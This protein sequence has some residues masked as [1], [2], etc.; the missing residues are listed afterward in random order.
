M[1]FD[2]WGT[3]DEAKPLSP[4]ITK[5]LS[6]VMGV[7]TD[8]DNTVEADRIVLSESRLGEAAKAALGKIVGE[9]KLT[10]DRDQR[11]ARA[12]GKSSLDLLE[13]R[14]GEEISAPDAVL[15][16]G[17]EEEILAILEYCSDNRIAVVP[18]GGGTSVVGGINPARGEF[19]AV[20]SLDLRRFDAIED[21]DP[22]SG[23]A[24][25]GAGL[26]GPHAEMLLADRGLQLGHFPQSF[27]YA[28][29]G[30]FAVTRS[31]GQNSAGYG[32]FDDMVRELTIVTPRGVFHP[33]KQSPASAAGPDLKE[34]VMGSEG[35]F[36]VVTRVRVHVH[37]IPQ[38]KRYEAFV[39]PSFA[40]GANALREVEQQGTGPTVIR[41]SD[42]IESAI[43]LTSS[44]AIGESSQAPQGCLCITVFEGTF[45]HA[46]SR[47]EE[48]RNLILANGGVSAGEAPARKWEEGRFGAPV[49][50]D[51]LLDAGALCETLETAT[52]WSNVPRL[53]AAVGDALATALNDSGT[54]VLV[55]CHISHVYATGCSLYFTIVAAQ[56]DNPLEQWRAAKKK[57]SQ[58]IEANGG[59]ITHHHAVGT[60]HMPYM[61][62]EIEPLGVELL[63]GIK[64]TLDPAGILNPGKLLP[65]GSGKCASASGESG[66]GQAGT[67]GSSAR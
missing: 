29:I 63:R 47:H 60:D 35:T 62:D 18:F 49:L 30:G 25:L 27:P 66:T 3:R 12:R 53:K 28:T 46:A 37:P 38:V 54:M 8:R 65:A 19:D 6:R 5:L 32:R 51:S 17:S 7:D 57:V 58:A 41:L 44:D 48:T 31:A 56:D 26:S 20:V 33:G 42:E 50:R 55:M 4:S 24:T 21:V 61:T 1:R 2:L 59:T 52:D 43:N 39:F 22:V 16:P 40:E 11:M 13:W 34:I 67:S 9:A 15:A 45:E 23:L 14:A 64:R 36:G 10:Q